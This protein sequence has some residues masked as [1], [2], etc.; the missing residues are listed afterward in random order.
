MLGVDQFLKRGFYRV[1]DNFIGQAFFVAETELRHVQ[2]PP[3]VILACGV[4][5][6]TSES[7]RETGGAAHLKRTRCLSFAAHIGYA[8]VSEQKDL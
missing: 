6:R 2:C 5:R 8:L 4:C 3:I 7:R 1:S